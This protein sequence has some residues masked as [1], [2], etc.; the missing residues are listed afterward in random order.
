MKQYIRGLIE[1]DEEYKKVRNKIEMLYCWC[2]LGDK[3][4]RQYEERIKQNNLFVNYIIAKISEQAGQEKNI[5]K[6]I[7]N[8]FICYKEKFMSKKIK[9]TE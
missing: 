9:K 3:T 8:V 1:C 5:G 4:S 6:F 2:V 7:N